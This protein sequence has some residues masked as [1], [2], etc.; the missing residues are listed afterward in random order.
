MSLR[1]FIVLHYSSSEIHMDRRAFLQAFSTMGALGAASLP[2][3]VLAAMAAYPSL[4]N[5]HSRTVLP[6][7]WAEDSTSFGIVAIGGAACC[8]LPKFSVLLPAQ[9]TSTTRTLAI[10]TSARALRHARSHRQILLSAGN[11][12]PESPQVAAYLAHAERTTIKHALDGMHL[13]FILAGMGGAAGSGIAP[14]VAEIARAASITTVVAAV[15]PFECEGAIR[16]GTAASAC[17]AMREGG[18]D[19]LFLLNNNEYAHA[20]GD[21]ATV[22]SVLDQ[23]TAHFATIYRSIVMPVAVPG[24][25][26]FDFEDMRYFLTRPGLTIAAEATALNG[27][28]AFAICA[29]AIA[30]PWPGAQRLRAASA[31]LVNIEGRSEELSLERYAEICH[32]VRAQC[33]DDV[34]FFSSA[35][36]F[37]TPGKPFRVSLLAS[38]IQS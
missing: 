2:V 38:G 14:V 30:Q 29:A 3:D 6:D 15:M 31:V 35:L 12:R 25:V 27:D 20:C 22:L 1:R 34:E 10:D 5:P 36:P 16:M 33:R 4:P 21:D 9:L 24:I 17:R 32:F 28:T 7:Q 13:V 19:A 37:D 26:G 18:T 11:H 23:A 8:I